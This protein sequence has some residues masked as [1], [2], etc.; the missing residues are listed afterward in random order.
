MFKIKTQ[1]DAEK[2]YKKQ[3]AAVRK[4]AQHE[5]FDI[6][7]EYWRIAEKQ[8]DAKIDSLVGS[9]DKLERA[10]IERKVIREHLQ[11]IENLLN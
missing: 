9:P 10:V 5:D 6:F 1:K 3:L 8:I 11:W 4:V 7:I 2:Y